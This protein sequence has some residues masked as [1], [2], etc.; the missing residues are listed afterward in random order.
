MSGRTSGDGPARTSGGSRARTSGR[1]SG[2]ASGA[3]SGGP[4]IVIRLGAERFALPATVIHELIDAPAVTWVPGAGTGVLGQ[5]RYRFRT[6]TAFDAAAA[7]GVPRGEGPGA[8]LVLRDA[9]RRIAIVVDDVEDLVDVEPSRV[10]PLPAGTDPDGLIA[11]V[12]IWEGAGDVLVSVVRG[13]P[14]LAR[15]TADARNEQG[16]ST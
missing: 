7:L 16:G 13:E 12:Y 1:T 14:F 4:H 8:A 11:G 10:L 3:V 9:A 6:V 5:L 2:R 15:V